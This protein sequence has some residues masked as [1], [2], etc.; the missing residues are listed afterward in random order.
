MKD[1]HTQDESTS[2]D[3]LLDTLQSVDP[4]EAPDIA[5][6]LAES[7]ATD[8]AATEPPPRDGVGESS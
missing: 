1:Q 4:A 5:E 3:E 2:S 6:S 8:L 7:L